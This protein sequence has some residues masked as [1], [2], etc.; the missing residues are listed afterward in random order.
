MN[1]KLFASAGQWN[2]RA[3]F[4]LNLNIDDYNFLH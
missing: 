3:G 1:E 4:V 2:L